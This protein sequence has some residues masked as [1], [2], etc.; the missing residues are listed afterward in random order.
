MAHLS[1]Q[2]RMQRQAQPRHLLYVK[3]PATP[4]NH[5]YIMQSPPCAMRRRSVRPMRMRP[6]PSFPCVHSQCPPQHAGPPCVAAGGATVVP[7]GRNTGAIGVDAGVKLSRQLACRPRLKGLW[8][9]PSGACR[10]LYLYRGVMG[11]GG[12]GV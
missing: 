3:P 8:K 9:L 6:M 12:R 5:L 2:Q 4:Y 7:L 11:K 1:S 10:Y